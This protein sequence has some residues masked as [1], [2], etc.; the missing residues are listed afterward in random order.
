MFGGIILKVLIGLLLASVVGNGWLYLSGKWK[1][2]GYKKQIE[3]L[4]NAQVKSDVTIE[5]QA[6][7]IEQLK[8]KKTIKRRVSNAQEKVDTDLNSSDAVVDFFRLRRKG[9]VPDSPNGGGSGP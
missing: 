3:E 4:Q 8:S 2:S 1:E 9:G 5:K 6:A 7:E